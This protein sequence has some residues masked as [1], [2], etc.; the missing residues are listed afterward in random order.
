MVEAA[1]ERKTVAVVAVVTV[2]VGPSPWFG[3]AVPPPPAAE[4][5]PFTGKGGINGDIGYR[6]YAE[7][8]LQLLSW[9]KAIPSTHKER[10][11]SLG[12]DLLLR[13]AGRREISY[14]GIQ[15]LHP[16]DL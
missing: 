5:E 13:E 7:V 15:I 8:F 1:A 11:N 2:T 6:Q 9:Q 4:P 14:P 3:A 10:C 12:V 16:D